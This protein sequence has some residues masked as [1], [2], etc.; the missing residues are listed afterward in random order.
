MV[1]CEVWNCRARS[2][3][4]TRPSRCNC[5][6]IALCRSSLSIRSSS[7][8]RPSLEEQM[9]MELGRHSSRWAVHFAEIFVVHIID[10]AI[11]AVFEATQFNRP[12]PSRSE[13]RI[14]E[15]LVFA[16]DMS[17]RMIEPDVV[18]ISE[19]LASRQHL[20][21]IDKQPLLKYL[22]ALRRQV[23]L[24]VLL[25]KVRQYENRPHNSAHTNGGSKV[26]R[27]VAQLD[28]VTKVG[29]GVAHESFERLPFG[30]DLKRTFRI[31]RHRH[32]E[33]RHGE[34]RV[35]SAASAKLHQRVRPYATRRLV[36]LPKEV[37]QR[38][39]RIFRTLV[40]V[41]GIVARRDAVHVLAIEFQ[42]VV[43]PLDKFTNQRL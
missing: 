35:G 3:T 36:N 18:K 22:L 6:R 27:P 33:M 14:V 7:L 34:K 11:S 13:E 10:D 21:F 8:F 19:I 32:I 23:R 39:Q 15:F 16:D 2:I 28:V 43:S 30:A 9:L 26:I 42:A 20:V 24:V 5:S 31:G 29:N 37:G 12:A 4:R 41:R 38:L 25:H 40:M 17:F 1:T